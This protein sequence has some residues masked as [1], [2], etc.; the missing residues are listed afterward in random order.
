[1]KLLVFQHVPHEHPGF[2]AQY[3]R[4][5]NIELNITELW[6]PYVMPK[7]DEHNALIILGGPMGVYEGADKYPSKN[8]EVNYIRKSLGRLPILGFCLGSQILAYGLGAKVYKNQ[9]KEIGYYNV[10]LTEEGKANRLF[11]GFASPIKV[12]QWHGDTFDLP[13]G[14]ELLATAPDCQ[15]QAFVYGTNAYGL[16]FHTEFTPE[17]IKKQIETDRQWIHDGFELNEN[18]L[19]REAGDLLELMENQTKSLLDNFV[20]VIK[21]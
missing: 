12:L 9:K 8:D 5:K 10:E 15:N 4:D 18:R 17:M 21:K 14:A 7:A 19:E 6:K 16:Q 2:I 1:M 20:S 11:R 13:K 3:A